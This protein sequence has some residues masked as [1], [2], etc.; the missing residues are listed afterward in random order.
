MRRTLATMRWSD[1]DALGHVHNARFLEYFEAARADL[2][3]ELVDL[4]RPSGMSLVVARH[5]IDYLVPLVYRQE[6]IPV[7]L[8]VERI[9]RSS[10]TLGY[11]VAE[12]DHSIIYGRAVTVMVAVDIATGRSTTLPEFIREALSQ[13]LREDGAMNAGP[14]AAVD[15]APTPSADDESPGI[16]NA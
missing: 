8:W 11:V 12:A 13:Y 5:E 15:V 3:N 10:I 2:V 7:D 4:G 14:S 9:G 6:P 1:M 16:T